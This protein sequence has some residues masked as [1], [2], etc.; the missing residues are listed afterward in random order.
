MNRLQGKHVLITGASQGLGRQLSID[1]ARAGAAAIAIT[2]RRR[3]ALNEVRDRIREAAPATRVAVIVAD[4]SRQED[5]ERVV[6]TALSEFGGRL[7][8]LVNNA[9]ALGPSPMP[10]MLD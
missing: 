7:D 1:F 5:I 3:E 9:S 4:L 8:V 10:F 6:A 2:A